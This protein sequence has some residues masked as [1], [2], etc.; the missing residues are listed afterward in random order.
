MYFFNPATMNLASQ[1]LTEK[2]QAD[3]VNSISLL[4]ASNS[5]P[6]HL[7]VKSVEAQSTIFTHILA[8]Q[9]L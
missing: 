9:Q 8:K 6:V 5:S 4:V 1:Q 7:V 2:K 3:L